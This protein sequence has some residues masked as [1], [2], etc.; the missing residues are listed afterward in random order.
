MKAEL[1]KT[2][3]FATAM[4]LAGT[5]FAQETATDGATTEE[6]ATD[7]ATDAAPA[8]PA[9]DMGTDTTTER[10]PGQTYVDEVFGDWE[11]KCAHNP[12]GDDPCQIYQLLKDQNDNPVAEISMLRLPDGGQAAAGATVVVPLETLLT[13]QLTIAVDGGQSRRYEFRFCAQLGCIAQI[14]FT[15]AEIASFK[16]GVVAKATI[17][18]AAAPDQKVELPVSLSGFTAAYDSLVPAN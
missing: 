15:G 13:Q 7:T 3:T 14:G 2:L 4:T 11:R 8:A 9:L 5:A 6:P 17:V 16:A 10:Q 12:N 18:P 1:L